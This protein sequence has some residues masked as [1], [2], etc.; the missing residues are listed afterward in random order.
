MGYESSDEELKQFYF[1]SWSTLAS[2]MKTMGP[3]GHCDQRRKTSERLRRPSADGSTR[4][5]LRRTR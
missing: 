1:Q 2:E 5:L 4:A 3:D